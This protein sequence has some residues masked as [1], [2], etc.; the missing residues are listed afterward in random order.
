MHPVWSVQLVFT[1]VTLVLFAFHGLA[2]LIAA[3]VEW[4][5]DLAGRA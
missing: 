2:N 1:A 3:F 4:H 5:R